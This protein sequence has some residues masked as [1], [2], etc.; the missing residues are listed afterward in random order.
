MDNAYDELV[1]KW[2][3]ILDI[4]QDGIEDNNLEDIKKAIFDTYHYYRKEVGDNTSIPRNRLIIYKYVAQVTSYM[5]TQYP[6]GFSEA[7]AESCKDFI[8]GLCF[9]IEEGFDAGYGA[10]PLPIGLTREGLHGGADSEADMSTYETFNKAFEENVE[11][12]QEVYGY[13]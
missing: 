8:E 4:M 11:E 10:N 3:E 12:L 1:T 6:R 7:E 2:S 9:C 13:E 5:M